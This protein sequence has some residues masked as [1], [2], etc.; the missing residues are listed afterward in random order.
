MNSYLSKYIP[1][2]HIPDFEPI[3]SNFPSFLPNLTITVTEAVTITLSVSM[4]TQK[5]TWPEMVGG[6]PGPKVGKLAKKIGTIFS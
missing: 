2:Y 6:Q 5:P 1:S 3:W 4:T